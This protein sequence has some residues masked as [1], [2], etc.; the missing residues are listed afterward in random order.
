MRALI[1]I[2]VWF[3]SHFAHIIGSTWM[4]L[5]TLT[6]RDRAWKIA[7][8]YDMLGNASTGGKPGEYISTRAF[9]ASQDGRRWACILCRL[10]DY[11]QKDHCRI[12]ADKQ[13]PADAGFFTPNYAIREAMDSTNTSTGEHR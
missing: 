1:L 12:S 9:Y 7:L 13:K 10:L 11:I 6:G 4:L 2:G 8:A 3:V 5:A